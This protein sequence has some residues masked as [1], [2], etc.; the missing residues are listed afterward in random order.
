MED[1][2]RGCPTFDRGI[3]LVASQQ[4]GSYSSADHGILLE[5]KVTGMV[6]CILVGLAGYYQ[7]RQP[8]PAF[9]NFKLS[10]VLKLEW[11]RDRPLLLEGKDSCLLL[12][13]GDLHVWPAFKICRYYFLPASCGWQFCSWPH[14]WKLGCACYDF[15]FDFGCLEY[16]AEYDLGWE[17]GFQV[18]RT[19]CGIRRPHESYTKNVR[20]IN[21]RGP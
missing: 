4:S 13:A 11:I 20:A 3:G 16:T 19:L 6:I 5:L 14:A 21:T 15:A 12:W 1:A 18:L 17:D 10:L 8:G 2:L 7:L 9:K